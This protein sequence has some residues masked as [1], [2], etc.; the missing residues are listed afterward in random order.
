MGPLLTSFLFAIGVATWTYNQSQKR[1][2]GIAQQSAIAGAV[3]GIV[4][5]IVFYTIFSTIIS[6]LPA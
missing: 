1:N 2:G 3:V 5:L 4:A 6:H